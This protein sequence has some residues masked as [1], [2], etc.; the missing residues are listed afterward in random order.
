MP[1]SPKIILRHKKLLPFK[2]VGKPEISR[3]AYEKK[4]AE[5]RQQIIQQQRVR[6][7]LAILALRRKGLTP[8]KEKEEIRKA[9]LEK[10]LEPEDLTDSFVGEILYDEE[11][12]ERKEKREKEQEEAW[13]IWTTEC[14]VYDS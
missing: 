1:S 12:K 5:R 11:A 6:R 9:G 7:E 3:A 13:R 4:I 10:E 14:P 2:G 8:T